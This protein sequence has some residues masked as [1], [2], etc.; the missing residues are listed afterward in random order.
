MKSINDIM[1]ESTSRF[2]VKDAVRYLEGI[3]R[4][5]KKIDQQR[6]IEMWVTQDNLEKTQVTIDSLWIK[7][8]EDWTVYLLGE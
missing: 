5:L 2:V 1:T 4:D 7:D 3:I 8:D 6:P